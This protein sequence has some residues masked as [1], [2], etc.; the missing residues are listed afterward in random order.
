MTEITSPFSKLYVEVL[1]TGRNFLLTEE[2]SFT[3]PGHEPVVTPVGFKTD[4]AS[5]PRFATFFVPK[6][7]RYTYPAVTHDY[8][9]RIA[10]TWEE[11]AGADWM[12]RNAM[13]V[14]G[15]GFLRRWVMWFSVYTAGWFVW[16]F[17]INGRVGIQAEED[18]KETEARTDKGQQ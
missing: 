10:K 15:V 2:F 3:Q 16:T 11:R 6:L 13:E 12:F 17:N 14:M 7:G 5:I 1:T 18:R 9:C 8:L 4:F